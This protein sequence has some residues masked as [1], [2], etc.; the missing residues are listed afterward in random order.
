MVDFCPRDH[1]KLSPTAVDPNAPD[2]A[3]FHL[4]ERQNKNSGRAEKRKENAL[5]RGYPIS[6]VPVQCSDATDSWRTS[7]KKC[8]GRQVRMTGLAAATPT[9]VRP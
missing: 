9:S 7:L 1:C 6:R 4:I 2:Y 3:D 5:R 8:V